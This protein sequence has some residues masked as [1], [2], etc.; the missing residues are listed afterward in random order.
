[1]ETPNVCA[2]SL[3][4]VHGSINS[5]TNPSHLGNKCS[6]WIPDFAALRVIDGLV[7][8]RRSMRPKIKGP[9]QLGACSHLICQSPSESVINIKIEGVRAVIR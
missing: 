5:G 8:G 9:G 7:K 4:G 6:K 1:M 3:Y 2:V